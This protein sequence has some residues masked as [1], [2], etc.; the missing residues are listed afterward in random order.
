MSAD[1]FAEFGSN[2]NSGASQSN[3]T[4]QPQLKPTPTNDPFAFLFS[5]TSQTASPQAFQSPQQWPSTK[6]QQ[7]TVSSWGT[8]GTSGTP[9]A[10]A[11]VPQQPTQHPGDDDEEGWG[12][13]EEAPTATSI[14]PAPSILSSNSSLPLSAVAPRPA[15]E[16]P[17]RNRIHRA[18]T[19]DLM[20][21]YLVALGGPRTPEPWQDRPSWE[22]AAATKSSGLE[23]PGQASQWNTPKPPVAQAKPKDTNVDVLF[24]ADDFDGAPPESED[25][26]GDFETGEE[27]AQAPRTASIPA[28]TAMADLIS[29]EFG[30]QAAHPAPAP[31]HPPTLV[32]SSNRKEPPTQLL[33]TLN[34]GSSSL[35]PSPLYP[36]A[37]RSPSFSDRNPFPGLAVTTPVSGTFP[38]ELK[39]DDEEKSPTPITAWPEA[40][41]ATDKDDWD[42]FADFPPDASSATPGQSGVSSTWD[43]D[44]VDAPKSAP[45]RSSSKTSQ[46]KT[47]SQEIVGPPPTNVPPPSILLSVFPEVLDDIDVKLYKPTANQ[48][49]AVKSRIYADPATL[50]Y[51][52]GFLALATVVA[53]ILAGRKKRWSRDKF[54]SQGMSISAAGSKSGM[55]LTG[56]DKAQAAREDR[57]AADVVGVW[58]DHVG[59]LRS[60]VAAANIGIQKQVVKLEP[61]KIPEINDHMAVTI[62]KL[63]PTAPRPCVV[64]GLKRDERV[65][66]V[67]FEVEDSFG[68][69]WVE[70]WGHKT[71]RNFWLGN[72]EKLRSR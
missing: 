31:A 44:A 3:Q 9:G 24:D 40:Q 58:R 27:K 26:F 16:P 48:A 5:P 35:S 21:N 23:S 52:G 17:A 59:K 2:F 42:A 33:S 50:A 47:S 65:K 57:E 28:Q 25:D 43:W 4:T 13:F 14:K 22:K 70:H 1:L 69:W 8:L 39:G 56:V 53:R 62:A 49:P 64:C 72:E 63:V 38:T 6:S 32:P 29:I 45:Q 12:D 36:Q 51:L 66:G 60:S 19:L 37:P 30:P 11:A 15:P 7:S 10:S 41:S 55:K 46:R 18:P 71:C 34:I 54:L 61:L 20:S 67:D 68:E